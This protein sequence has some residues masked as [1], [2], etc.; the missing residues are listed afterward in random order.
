MYIPL[1]IALV[2]AL[3]RLLIWLRNAVRLPALK[4]FASGAIALLL[5]IWLGDAVKLNRR[6][7]IS[8]SQGD[9]K[10]A[11]VPHVVNN[12]ML[13]FIQ[14]ASAPDKIFI[15]EAYYSYLSHLYIHTG[16][17]IK[18]FRFLPQDLERLPQTVA[19]AV[20]GDLLIWFH[21]PYLPYSYGLPE[22]EA[23]PALE[24]IATLQSG[25]VFRIN[26]F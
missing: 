7:I 11:M 10:F 1:L 22:L 24:R 20:T 2:F 12:D 5:L 8:A 19:A 21:D 23:M 15:N 18:D 16:R 3:D 25:V 6:A 14:K 17:P 4:T 13:Q 26:Q 9:G